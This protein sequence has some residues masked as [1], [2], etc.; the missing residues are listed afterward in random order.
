MKWTQLLLSGCLGISYLAIAS[1]GAEVLA[2]AQ[3][4]PDRFGKQ[5]G[6]PVETAPDTSPDN[7]LESDTDF[8]SQFDNPLEDPANPLEDPANPLEDQT[9]PLNNPDG[10]SDI[11]IE[12]S[13]GIIQ[14]D[15]QERLNPLDDSDV[16]F[17][18]GGLG[19][20]DAD[21]VEEQTDGQ[22]PATGVITTPTTPADGV[23]PG[24]D[25]VPGAS[26]G[27]GPGL[28]EQTVGRAQLETFAV[29][30]AQAGLAETLASGQ[31]Y[32]LLAPTDAAFAALPSEILSYLLQPEN[33]P[34]LQQILSYHVIPGTVT[35]QDLTSGD[36]LETLTGDRLPI[37][38]NNANALTIGGI[39][40]RQPNIPI[41][42][43]VLHTI[44]QVI[45]PRAIAVKLGAL[46]TEPEAPNEGQ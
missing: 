42:N 40:I 2:L 20:P 34:L 36:S 41:N 12:P 22:T 28:L 23:V 10:T 6:N 26:A 45:L 37:Q 8:D 15:E 24:G 14:P 27:E 13:N 11:Q 25:T 19:D 18:D 4:N 16:P 29:A 1:L 30:I 43:G 31:P 7:P 44:D 9:G 39:P 21:G 5:L 38:L 17:E 33:Q 46:V 32:T 35:A 3:T